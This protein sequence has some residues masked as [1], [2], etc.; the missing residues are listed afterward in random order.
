MF[1][2]LSKESN[3][4]S[5]PV[6]IGFLLLIVIFFNVFSFSY[7]YFISTALT[8]GG[9]AL[10]YFC[11]NAI[12]L[13]NYSHLPLFLYTFFVFAFYPGDLDVGIATALFT[14][15]LLIL[16]FTGHDED[17]RNK[18]YL[19]AGAILA[20]NY[21]VL[22]TTW[23]TA[24]FVMVHIF[25]TS[26][27]MAINLFRVFL[28]VVLVILSYFS[29]AYFLDWNSWNEAYFPFK[30]FKWVTDYSPLYVLIPIALLSLFSVY[31][32][33]KS[34]NNNSPFTR[35]KYTFLLL[36][37]VA[38]LTSVVLYM[39]TNYEYLL[40]LVLPVTIIVSRMLNILPK[41]WMKECGLW[42]MVLC[43]I[44]FKYQRLIN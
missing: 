37:L 3:I 13:N 39:G 40:L 25:A 2:L 31:E 41:Y 22:P 28:G 43:L 7:L 27:R 19:L 14:N 29:L 36:F 23:P 44:I 11:F 15:S 10:G 21:L 34:Y 38:Q 30:G 32:F 33:F 4:F 6:Y 16:M 8:F 26:R 17:T 5:I 1:K 35:F 18:S 12:N 24:V 20:V 9:I 42:L